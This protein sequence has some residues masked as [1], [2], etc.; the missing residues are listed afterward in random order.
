MIP[1]FQTLPIN[2]VDHILMMTPWQGQPDYHQDYHK[3]HE[4]QKLKSQ[5]ARNSLKNHFQITKCMK[6]L[7]QSYPTFSL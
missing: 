2:L 7:K 6:F 1:Q 3:M 4:T 5:N